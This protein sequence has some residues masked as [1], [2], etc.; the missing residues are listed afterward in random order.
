MELRSEGHRRQRP[1]SF[2]S[3]RA[4]VGALDHCTYE[5]VQAPVFFLSPT[6]SSS[7]RR[8]LRHQSAKRRT[9]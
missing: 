2:S 6:W 8:R 3:T 9:P 1:H 5:L 4:D 7:S